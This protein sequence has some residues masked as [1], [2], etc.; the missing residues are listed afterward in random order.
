MKTSPYILIFI[1]LVLLGSC[2]KFVDPGTPKDEIS[3]ALAFSD[4]KTS[5]ASVVGIYSSM[6]QLNYEFA[7]VLSLVLPAMEA[8]E[9]GYSFAYAAYDEFKNNAVRPSNSFVSTLWAQPYSYIYQANAVIEGLALATGVTEP[10][11]NQLLGEAKFI[12]A[13]LY[14]YLVNNFGDVPLILDTDYKKNNTLPRTPSADVYASIIA[15]LQD[16]KSKLYDGYPS[17]D[18]VDAGGEHIRPNKAAAGALL[19]RTYLYTKQWALAESEASE[20]ISNS[21]YRLM[22]KTE[23]DKVFLINSD[24][25]IWQLQAINTSGGRNTWEGFLIVP[26]STTSTPYF[27]LVP[28][29]LRD[30]FQTGDLRKTN[31]VG[32]YT[33]KN[34][35]GRDT[36]YYYPHKY[37]IR[38]NVTPVQ[39]Y[40][41]ILRFSEQYLIRAEA[42]LNQGQLSAAIEDLNAIRSRAGLEGIDPTSSANA[43]KAALEQECR[44]EL[45]AEWGH[46]WYDLRR[47]PSLGGDASKTRA[48]DV[49]GP[50]KTGWQSKAIYLPIPEDAILSN[51]NLTQN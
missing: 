16:A 37:K 39:E 7:N 50:V 47:W 43:V 24:E 4:D 13:F 31:W 15:D 12:R 22:D 14:F 3:S 5:T 1:A 10:F 35:A 18:K 42:R 33:T 17:G 27:R 11:K 38:S 32:S 25:A 29:G 49:L 26:V 8:D 40:S 46:R 51:P 41:M 20:V 30:A 9:F 45:F 21:Q 36:T 2:S 44:I 6:N 34:S 19:A 48:D 28:N 23:L